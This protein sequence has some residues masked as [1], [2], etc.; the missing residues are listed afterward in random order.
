M[1]GLECSE[2]LLSSLERTR[3]IDS[4]FYKKQSLNIAILMKKMEAQ[5]IAKYV[6]VS[7]G[8]H[9][10]ISEKFI[11]KGIP[12]YR[13]QDIHN[14]FIDNAHPICIDFDTYNLPHMQRSHIKKGDL[15]L[16]IVGTIGKSALVYSDREATCSC[17]L[18]ILRST[19]IQ[20][21]SILAVYL[22][23]K[24]G[25]DQ[26]EKFKRGAVQM[27][28]LLE[29]MDQILIPDFTDVFIT[30]IH[31]T[32][33]SSYTYISKANDL[34]NS[35][36]IQLLSELQFNHS[37]DLVKRNTEK[38]LSESFGISGR[39]DA[40][41][42]QPK[43]DDLFAIL[44]KQVRKP[45]GQLVSMM[46]S[47][48]PGSEY[49]GETGIPFIRV[50]DVSKTGIDNPSIMIPENIETNIDRLYLKKDTILFSKDGS[51]GVAYKVT[52]YMKAITSSALLHLRVNNTSE[53]LPDYLTLVL[54]SE[55]VQL[56]AERDASGAIIQHWKPS[57]IEKVVI[58]ILPYDMQ[59]KI[60]KKIQQSFSLRKKADNLIQIAV[61]AVELAIEQSEGIA[62][63]W[64]KENAELLEE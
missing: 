19:N 33:Q 42:Y 53:I 61:K 17:K 16:S 4:E 11:E 54:N 58:P 12:Y 45:L 37:N 60:S 25:Y 20:T 46:K 1:D 35:V 59:L 10:G 52:E 21:S 14:F 32:L 18:A 28:L 40:E 15:L 3:R 13:G 2:I 49:Y 30:I 8:N 57:D 7:D 47:I 43:Y 26:V 41:Y 39:L 6:T 36:E 23:T 62:A 34:Y 38:K 48:E 50:S 56:Q 24:Y 64:L 31:R 22:K 9:M 44:S 63:K 51:V 5:S 29:D 27:G 55:I